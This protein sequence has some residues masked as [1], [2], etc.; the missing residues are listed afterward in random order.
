MNVEIPPI[1]SGLMMLRAELDSMTSIVQ[2]PPRESTHSGAVRANSAIEFVVV[3]PVGVTQPSH[4][5]LTTVGVNVYDGSQ[6]DV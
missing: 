6:V 4:F 2:L 3:P 5:G 1:L